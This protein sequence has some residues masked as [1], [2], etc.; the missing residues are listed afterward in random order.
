MGSPETWEAAE[1]V[2]EDPVGDDE[3]F[4]FPSFAMESREVGEWFM[5]WNDHFGCCTHVKIGG[6]K[7]L[8]SNSVGV[9]MNF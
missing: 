3:Y 8:E 2:S 1:A 5:L 9:E 4:T 7:Q 6:R